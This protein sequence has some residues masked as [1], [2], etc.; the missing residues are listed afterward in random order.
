VDELEK[1]IAVAAR[2]PSWYGID[3]AEIENRRR[4]TSSARTQV[5]KMYAQ[6]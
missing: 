3:D 1:A 5:C 4:W 2:E 6:F